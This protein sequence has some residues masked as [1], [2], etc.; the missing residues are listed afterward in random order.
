MT[1]S[2]SGRYYLKKI[3]TDPPLHPFCYCSIRIC[4]CQRQKWS[5]NMLLSRPRR[6]SGLPALGLFLTDVA[7]VA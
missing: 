3:G 5:T 1:W 2:P 7:K 4:H 6:C